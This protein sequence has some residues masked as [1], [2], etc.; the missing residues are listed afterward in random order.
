MPVFGTETKKGLHKGTETSKK[1]HYNPQKMSESNNCSC[2]WPSFISPPL[3]YVPLPLPPCSPQ[4]P[5]NGCPSVTCPRETCH[6]YPPDDARLLL[7]SNASPFPSHSKILSTPSSLTK[8]TT[9]RS[10]SETNLRNS[11][12]ISGFLSSSGG[13]RTK[14]MMTPMNCGELQS[15]PSYRHSWLLQMS[16]QMLSS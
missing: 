7:K 12:E 2:H 6:S 4:I 9:V 16:S 14:M 1:K 13:M 5:A 3:F 11:R 8:T 10:R 15:V